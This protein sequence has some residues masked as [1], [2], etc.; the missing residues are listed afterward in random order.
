NGPARHPVQALDTQRPGDAELPLEDEPDDPGE[1]NVDAQTDDDRVGPQAGD[2]Q[3]HEQAGDRPDEH[4]ADDADEPAAGEPAEQD[5][6]HRPGQHLSFQADVDH[7][8]C[9]VHQPA[10]GG[11]QQRHHQQ[12]GGTD[13]GAHAAVLLRLR[14]SVKLA[15]ANTITVPC[16]T[17]TMSSGMLSNSWMVVPALANAPNM[18]AA[19]IN[20]HALRRASSA[21]AMPVKPYSAENPP[22]TNLPTTPSACT[23]PPN[24]AIAPVAT[25]AANTTLLTAMPWAAA[26]RALTPTWCRSAPTLVRRRKTQ[27][28]ATS[29]T[30]IRKPMLSDDGGSSRGNE[31]GTLSVDELA[32]P[33]AS[34]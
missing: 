4:G 22:T 28:A 1:Q 9:A 10:D 16:S 14:C 6:D 15:T 17:S 30:A 24:A 20:P 23:A 7:A 8:G 11:E 33:G 27:Y 18:I 25:M 26:N 12:Q 2:H 19:G 34:R 3:R 21:T 32:W 5:A 13:H 31:N 29:A